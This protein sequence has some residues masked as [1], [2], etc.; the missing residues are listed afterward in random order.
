M[1]VSLTLW[2]VIKIPILSWERFLIIS[3]ISITER[4]SIPAKGSSSK[5]K[6]GLDASVLAIFVLLL[7]PPDNLIPFVCENSSKLNSWRIESSASF[8]PLLSKSFL[9]SNAASY[10]SGTSIE[11]DGGQSGHI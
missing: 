7:S 2:S 1:R 10:I 4:G 6:L 5:I 3:W 9:C 11:V 8:L